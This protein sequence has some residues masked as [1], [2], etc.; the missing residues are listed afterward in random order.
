MRFLPQTLHH[1]RLLRCRRASCHSSLHFSK[2]CVL[3]FVSLNHSAPVT[4]RQ[5]KYYMTTYHNEFLFLQGYRQRHTEIDPYHLAQ[6]GCEAFPKAAS[7]TNCIAYQMKF[8]TNSQTR[9]CCKQTLIRHCTVLH[10]INNNITYR[11]PEQRNVPESERKRPTEAKRESMAL[12]GESK[13]NTK[14]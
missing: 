2:N 8:S 9:R 14:L 11:Y 6:L 12:D 13:T 7:T 5:N 10:H 4:K 1:L 3:D